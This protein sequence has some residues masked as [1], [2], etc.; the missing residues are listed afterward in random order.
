MNI[1][2]PYEKGT[3]FIA[4]MFIGLRFTKQTS[5]GYVNEN[6]MCITTKTANKSLNASEKEIL[7]AKDKDEF[8]LY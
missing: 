4:P 2:D 7:I 6:S 5:R 8:L 1:R 3:V